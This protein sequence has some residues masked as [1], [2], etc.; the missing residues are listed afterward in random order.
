MILR[1]VNN[2]LR[3]ERMILGILVGWKIVGM[4]WKGI[5]IKRFINKN[6]DIK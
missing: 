6:D 4:S 3:L 5:S 1:L 2:S